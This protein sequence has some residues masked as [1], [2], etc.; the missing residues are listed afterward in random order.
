M[1]PK[2]LG[3]ISYGIYDHVTTYQNMKEKYLSCIGS[4][5]LDVKRLFLMVLAVTI[6]YYTIA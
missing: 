1:N 2:F 4:K 6:L 5:L 3:G